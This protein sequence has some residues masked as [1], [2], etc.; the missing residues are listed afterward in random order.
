MSM[1]RSARFATVGLALGLG[2]AGPD[3]AAAAPGD[4]APALAAVLGDALTAAATVPGSRVEVLGVDGTHTGC[5]I[6]VPE[7]VEVSRD[8]TGS[9]RV[10]VKLIGAVRAGGTPCEAWSWVRFRLVARVPVATR[11][12]RAG[13]AL[14]GAT[15]LDEREIKT[16]HTPADTAVLEA[17]AL[18][19]RTLVAGQVV[20]ADL[21]RSAGPRPGEPVKVVLVAGALAIEETGRAVPC[22]RNHNCA[23]LPSGRHVD[24][25]FV[26]G[27]LL[28]QMP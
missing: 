22:A 7:R 14:A 15:R 9:G 25:T 20:E 28:V 21:V 5:P 12:V 26:D 6:A 11:S 1:S 17:G 4:V 8:V 18:A 3:P 13:E 27:R 2:L 23:V 24:G 19:D 10:A 16:G